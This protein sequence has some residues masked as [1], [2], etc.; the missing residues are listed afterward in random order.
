[1]QRD[2]QGMLKD[3]E[4]PPGG[5]VVAADAIIVSLFSCLIAVANDGK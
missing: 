3:P 1:M 2:T 4:T 5:F